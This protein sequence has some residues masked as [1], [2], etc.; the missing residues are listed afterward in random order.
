[1]V[2]VPLFAI[3]VYNLLINTH[4]QGNTFTVLVKSPIVFC[5]L[6][7]FHCIGSLVRGEVIVLNL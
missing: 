5:K 3:H 2:C 6:R 7:L 4:Y 1:M